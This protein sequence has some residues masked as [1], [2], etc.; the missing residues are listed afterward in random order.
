MKC[1]LV[2]TKRMSFFQSIVRKNIF[3]KRHNWTLHLHKMSRNITS[4]DKKVAYNVF[5]ASMVGSI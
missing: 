3:I 4:E 2:Y 1:S 5:M